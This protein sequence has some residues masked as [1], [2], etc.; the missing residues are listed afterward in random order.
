MS[1]CSFLRE[2]FCREKAQK[3][4]EE[5][6]DIK[7]KGKETKAEGRRIIVI[8]GLSDFFSCLRLQTELL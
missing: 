6:E 7:E 3:T 4:Q 8:L 1:V 2:V 5:E